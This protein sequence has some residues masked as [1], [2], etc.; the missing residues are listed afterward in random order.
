[1]VLVELSV[2]L[3]NPRDERKSAEVKG[4]VDTGA[5]LTVLPRNV[6]KSL[7]IIPKSTAT[8]LTA[9]GPVSIDIS[10]V[11]IELGGK[12]ETIR[13]AISDIIDRVLIGVTTL[14]ILGLAVDPVTSQLKDSM[15]LLY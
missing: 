3:R 15:Y 7:G 8:V 5:T 12:K 2:T 1:M 14:E 9:G 6:A 4:L 10:N 13:V 11:E